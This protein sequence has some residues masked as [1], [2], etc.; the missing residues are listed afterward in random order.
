VGTSPPPRLLRRRYSPHHFVAVGEIGV[1]GTPPS[2]RSGGRK[3]WETRKA[4]EYRS[5]SQEELSDYRDISNNQWV[6]CSPISSLSLRS[7]HRM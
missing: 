4:P 2:L 6:I 3:A 5:L 1:A 7:E